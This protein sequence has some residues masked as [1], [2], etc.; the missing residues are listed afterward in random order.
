MKIG[1]VGSGM[2]VNMMMDI[3]N[4]FKD[5]EITAMWCRSEDKEQAEK[6]AVEFKIPSLTSDY[7]KFL[8]NPSFDFVYIGM[9]NC[10]HYEYSKK[11]LEAG[12]NVVCEKPFTSNN[13]QAKELIS[14]AKEKNFF[15]FESCL[16]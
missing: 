12:K 5:I 8:E 1:I 6:M 16:P 14:I 10:A 4:Q 15:I 7:D 2:I 3:W 13:V 11:A 9:I